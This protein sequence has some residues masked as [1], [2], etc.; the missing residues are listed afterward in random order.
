MT[1]FVKNN[2]TNGSETK[3]G[4]RVSFDELYAF[5]VSSIHWKYHRKDEK[6]NL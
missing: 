5:G 2:T 6:F 1:N 4:R 3:E